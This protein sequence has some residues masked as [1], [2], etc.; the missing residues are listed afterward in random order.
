MRVGGL[1]DLDGRDISLMV[2]DDAPY[3]R[4]RVIS[5]G[6]GMPHAR[7]LHLFSAMALAGVM[8]GCPMCDVLGPP[9][10]LVNKERGPKPVGKGGTNRQ[11]RARQGKNW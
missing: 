4:V 2:I 10:A 1:A 3:E 6:D 7:A 11:K 8:G 5:I 9:R